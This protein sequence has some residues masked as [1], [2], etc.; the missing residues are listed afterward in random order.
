MTITIFTLFVLYTLAS[1]ADGQDVKPLWKRWLGRKLEGY[2][3]SLKPISYCKGVSCGYYRLA[4]IELPNLQ[5]K[6][7]MLKEELSER[8]LCPPIEVTR[9]DGKRI[10]SRVMVSEGDLF[11]ARRH[12]EMNCCHGFPLSRS[13]NERTLIEDSTEHCVR[14]LFKTARQ[15]VNVTVDKECHWPDIVITAEMMVGKKRE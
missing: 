8:Y 5:S 14:E 11:A 7:D 3:N 12:A 15:F 4:N 10:E 2:A 9:F 1:I 13:L 6:V